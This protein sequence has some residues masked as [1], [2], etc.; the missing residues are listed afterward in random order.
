MGSDGFIE[1]MGSVKSLS[2]LLVTVKSS[3][4][5]VVVFGTRVVVLASIIMIAVVIIVIVVIVIIVIVSAII[6]TLTR[7]GSRAFGCL[8]GF[9][10][11]RA[12]VLVVVHVNFPVHSVSRPAGQQSFSAVDLVGLVELPVCKAFSSVVSG[13]GRSRA[14]VTRG[15]VC[16]A[17]GTGLA[18]CRLEVDECV[19]ADSAAYDGD[20]VPGSEGFGG[21]GCVAPAAHILVQCAAGAGEG[22][23]G[24]RFGSG[25]GYCPGLRRLSLLPVLVI[26]VII[27]FIVRFILAIDLVIINLIIVILCS[28]ARCVIARVRLG[29]LLSKALL[30]LRCCPSEQPDGV[31]GCLR[32]AQRGKLVEL[33]T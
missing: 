27:A 17:L 6:I 3:I 7:L 16:S 30:L 28:G 26:I 21:A 11:S 4:A 12:G 5:L 14:P 9:G 22:P 18:A 15:E 8:S 1:L 23:A 19:A 24:S 25:A 32:V 10:C 20:V 2:R 33:E 31:C 13:A 29:N